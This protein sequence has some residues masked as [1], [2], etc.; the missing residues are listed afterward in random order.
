MFDGHNDVLSKLASAGPAGAARR[1]ADDRGAHID[2][3]RAALGGFGGGLFAVWV[4]S[5]GAGD[6]D[7]AAMSQAWFNVPLPPTVPQPEALS[8]VIGQVGIF[9]ELAREGLLAHC[10]TAGEVQAA[11]AEG[12]LAAVLHLEGAEAIDR[13]LA[14]LDVL[15]AAGLRSLGP[16]WSRPNR[17]GHGVPFRFPSGPDTGPGLTEDGLRLVDRCTELGILVDVSHLTEAGFWDIARRTAKPLV[18]THSN[19]HALTPAARNLT[20]GQLSAIGESGGM[21][22]VNFASA[23]LRKD[24]RMLPDVPLDQVIAHIDHLIAVVGEDGVGFGSDYDGALV[25]AA[26]DGVERLPRLRAAMRAHGYDDAL[27]EKL[28]HRNWLRVLAKVWGA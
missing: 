9:L 21:V 19:A 1:F 3:A 24:G 15:H 20:D 12:R 5:P 6:I 27:M 28:C 23:F 7:Y 8:A 16:V 2:V 26:I 22:G 14:T 13:D 18:A 4:P 11:L 17:F 10:R 25:P